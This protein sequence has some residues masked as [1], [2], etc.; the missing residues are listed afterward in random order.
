MVE[1]HPVVCYRVGID[2]GEVG[3]IAA[4]A[5][6]QTVIAAE[7]ISAAMVNFEATA[8]LLTA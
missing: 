7:G 6:Q 5:P 4:R 8:M 3:Y 2:R 1:R